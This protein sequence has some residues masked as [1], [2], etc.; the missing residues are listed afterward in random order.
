MAATRPWMHYS[1]PQRHF[2]YMAGSRGN[3]IRISERLM[4]WRKRR[5]LSQMQLAMAATCSQRHLSFLALGRTKPSREMV[6][7]LSTVLDIPLRQSKG[8]H[9]PCVLDLDAAVRYRRGV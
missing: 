2:N 9:A 1:G 6:L 5:G 4:W 8:R 7:R 3:S